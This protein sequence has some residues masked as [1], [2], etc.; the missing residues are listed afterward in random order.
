MFSHTPPNPTPTK[1]VIYLI[2]WTVLGA[3][4]GILAR[5]LLELRYLNWIQHSNWAQENSTAII[6]YNGSVL[7]PALGA[8]LF[9][10]G[11]LLG[12]FLGRFFWQ[13]IYV[14]QIYWK[15]FNK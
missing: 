3:L 5:I 4:L 1:K 7:H 6:F 13:K 12:F 10:A 14:E 15:K 11:A 8:G 2:S 9:I